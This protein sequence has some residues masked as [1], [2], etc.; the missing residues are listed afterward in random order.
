MAP[1]KIIIFLF[2]YKKWKLENENEIQ[3]KLSTSK[4]VYRNRLY[5]EISIHC[6]NLDQI[7][8]KLFGA[9]KNTSKQ[10]LQ[11]LVGGLSK[12]P[13][14]RWISLHLLFLANLICCL[15]FFSCTS[16]AAYH[17]FYK[18]YPGTNH[19]CI[20]QQPNLLLH[21]FHLRRGM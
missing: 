9:K 21:E 14:H 5:V 13:P 11:E 7:F 10:L 19:F 20:S 15:R 3:D 1:I 8:N 12:E 6:P 17:Q 18:L 2:F 16:L 4:Y